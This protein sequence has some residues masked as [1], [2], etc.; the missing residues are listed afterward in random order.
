MFH[1]KTWCKKT[2]FQLILKLPNL[3]E[4]AGGWIREF[5]NRIQEP[6]LA[7]GDI[8]AILGNIMGSEQ[9]TTL[10]LRACPKLEIYNNRHD[11]VDFNPYRPALWA[12]LREEYPSKPDLNSLQGKSL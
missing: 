5:E 4:G 9:M 2:A 7:I 1:G 8:K 10:M 12:M 6:L 11:G 3:E